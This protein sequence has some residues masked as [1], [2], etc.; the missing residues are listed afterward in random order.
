MDKVTFIKIAGQDG[1]DVEHAIIDHGNEQ[2]TSMLKS[3]YDEQQAEAK[4]PKVVDEAA[5][6]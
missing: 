5:P 6:K 4:A 2:F 3:T 1:K